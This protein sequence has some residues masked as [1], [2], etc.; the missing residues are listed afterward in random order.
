MQSR[1]KY[2]LDKH[3]RR[4][5][6][7]YIVVML[8]VFALIFFAGNGGYLQAWLYSILL[9]IVA[10]FILSIPRYIR[11]DDDNLEIHCVV[12]MTRIEI[13]DVASVRRITRG[14]YPRLWLI[15]GSYGFFGYYGYFFDFKQWELIKVYA[16]ERENL[17][18]IEDIYEQKYIVSCREADRLIEAVMQA[19][20]EGCCTATPQ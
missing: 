13:R 4:L 18:E 3:C 2:K 19:K 7:I 20:L 5:S 14:E 17:V 10:L 9:A 12:E 8:G 15:L 6:V 11:V 1:F 16:T